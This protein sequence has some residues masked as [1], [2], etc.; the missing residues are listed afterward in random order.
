MHTG[1]VQG[2]GSWD[3]RRYCLFTGSPGPEQ[4]KECSREQSSAKKEG[5][6][7]QLKLEPSRGALAPGPK[8]TEQS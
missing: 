1:N 5:Q 8:C 6:V 4:H 3:D 7:Q 2:P